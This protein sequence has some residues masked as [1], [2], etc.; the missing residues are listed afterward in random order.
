MDFFS[1]SQTFPHFLTLASGILRKT[2]RLRFRTI[3][4]RL[5]T[6]RSRLQT[7][8]WFHFGTPHGSLLYMQI[9]SIVML[10]LIH[11]ERALY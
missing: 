4:S 3:H 1:L 5:Q 2:I 6:I 11:D 9:N 7:I 8:R 10:Y